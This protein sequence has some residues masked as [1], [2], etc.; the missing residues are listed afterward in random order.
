M[1]SGEAK[2]ARQALNMFADRRTDQRITNDPHKVCGVETP[3]QVRYVYQLCNHLKEHEAFLD[4]P[5]LPPKCHQPPITLREL[6]FKNGLMAHPARM[7]NL[8]ALVQ[9]GGAKVSQKVLTTDPVS[10]DSASISLND[11]VVQGDF[12]VSVFE[13]KHEGFNPHD[14]MMKVPN[15]MKAKGL[16]LLF[17]VHTHFMELGDEEQKEA[18]QEDRAEEA[19]R[20]YEIS[21]RALD[22]AHKKVKKGKHGAG[23]SVELVYSLGGSSHI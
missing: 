2:R 21:V 10:P 16:V 19:L 15:A 3:S 17:L 18:Y 7:K 8:I 12:R 14:E 4:S 9:C 20:V 11:V 23:S 1:Y 13:E 22:K 5:I 6:R